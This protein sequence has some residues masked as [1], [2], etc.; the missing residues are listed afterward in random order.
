MQYQ[1][2]IT[3]M[4]CTGCKNLIQ[5]FLEDERIGDKGIFSDIKVDNIQGNAEFNSSLNTVEIEKILGQIFNK[6]ELQKYS[7]SNL[8]TN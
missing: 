6:V 8:V 1:I 3:G 2:N 7:Y 4:H 5:M